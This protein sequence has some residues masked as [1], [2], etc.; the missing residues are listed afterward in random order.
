MFSTYAF[1]LTAA[2]VA[3][4]ATEDVDPGR[5]ELSDEVKATLGMAVDQPASWV[6]VYDGRSASESARRREGYD[7]TKDILQV[8]LTHVAGDRYV[9]RT[10]LAAPPN[11]D[12]TVHH[13]YVDADSDPET[14]RAGY[15]VEYMLT[16][17]GGSGRSNRYEPGGQSISGPKVRFAVQDNMLLTS[18]DVTLGADAA[19]ARFRM[20]VLCHTTTS[21]QQPRAAMS[22]STPRILVEGVPLNEREKIMLPGDYTEHHRVTGTFGLDVVRPLL[23]DPQVVAVPYDQLEI[24]GFEVDQFTSLRYGHLRRIAD[25]ARAWHTVA[26]PGR[27]FVGFLMYDDGSDQRIAIRLNGE[28]AGVAVVDTGTRRHGVYYLDAPRELAVGDVVTLQALGRGGKH[29]IGYLLLM[30]EAPEPRRVEYHVQNTRWIA[31]VNTEGE[32]WIS[33]TTTWPS[34]S[35]FEYGPTDDFGQ[36]AVEDCTRLVHRAR[37]QGLEPG[38][39]Y[40]GRGVGTAADGSFYY[41]PTIEFAAVPTVPPPT[42]EGVTRVPLTVRNQHDVDA[43]NWPVTGGV[44]FPQ[45]ALASDRDVRLTRND[46]EVPAQFKPLGTWPDGSIKWLL[47]TVMADVTAGDHAVYHLEFGRQVTRSSDGEGLAPMAA[48]ENG[49]VRIDTGAAVF[50]VDAH[51]Q[52]VGPGGPLVTEL[53]D[54]DGRRFTSALAD[55]RLTIEENGPVRTVVKTEGELTGEDGAKSFRIEQRF[56]AWR[57]Q[58]L[59]RVHH[60]F[61]NTLPDE[62]SRTTLQT[63]QSRQFADVKRLSLIAPI[64]SSAWRAPLVDGAP[65]TLES[66]EHVWQRLDAEFVASDGRPAAGRIVGGLISEDE[67]AAVSVRDF[68][69][70]YPK[71]FRVTAEGVCVDLCPAFE[72][73]L[74]DAFAFEKEGHQLFYYLRDG[75]YTI[76][77]GMAKTHELL[78]DFGPGADV[79]TKLFQRPLLLTADPDWYCGSLAFYHVAPRDEQ[80]FPVYE[81]AIDRNLAAYVARRERQRD[82]GMLNYGDWYGERGA[83]WGNVEYDTQHA[84]FLE[85]IRSGNPDAFFLGEAAE[86]HHRDIDTVHWSPNAGERGM[87][88]IHQM[89]HVGGY[90]DE[91]VP[92]TLGIPRAGG[93]IGHAWTEGHFEHYFLTGDPRSLETGTAVADYF[94]HRELSRPYDWTSARVPGWHLIMLASALAATND[95]YYLNAARIVMD[96]VL[97]TQDIEPRELPEYQKQPG[98]THQ[99]GGWTRMMVPGHCHCEPR[100]RGN[101]G[102]MVTILLAGMTYYH[103]VTQDPAVKQAI[104]LGARYLVDE[105]YSTETHGFRYTSCPEMPYRPGMLPMYAEGMARAYRWTGEGRLLDPLTT[106]LL[107]GAGG[108]NYGKGFSQYYRSAPRLLADL[109]E[110]ELTL[111]SPTDQ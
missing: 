63:S 20:W 85:Y 55:A 57:G 34:D 80:R 100:H 98:R 18:A 19:G 111:E 8:E 16:V 79:R 60:T 9:W 33:W 72:A 10:L 97:E 35:R 91:T 59:V 15:G 43:V 14:G 104:I 39:T 68:W 41:G 110:A 82:Y 78:L 83:N 64:S 93:D 81:Q 108:S 71:G 107:L 96:R 29:G 92:G 56:E 73:G 1:L 48:E 86:I 4:Q 53:V 46:Q 45:G 11:L 58:S 74:Y 38:V 90:Y 99:W 109:S 21:A 3:A 50:R 23:V 52:L 62:V 51:G 28:L 27:Y 24:D 5:D 36:A 105:F 2:L 13:I 22:S 66:G 77:R 6:V 76:K 30:P 84:F 67:D 95:P 75:T 94:T 47:V 101:A 54:G 32:V 44:P 31:P 61:V 7:P 25:D 103:D 42:R 12:D 17:A 65:L 106:G 70:N 89:G 87:V 69:Q 102:F 37:L 88:Y 26:T 49:G 40:Y